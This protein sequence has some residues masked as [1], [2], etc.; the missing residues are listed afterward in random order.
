MQGPQNNAR[1]AHNAVII[2]ASI[3]IVRNTI[4]AREAASI[5]QTSFPAVPMIA[6]AAA[7]AVMAIHVLIPLTADAQGNTSRTHGS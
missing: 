4:P 7:V 6:N 1:L 3:T 2:V 5:H